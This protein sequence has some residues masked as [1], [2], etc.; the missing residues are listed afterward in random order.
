[1]TT[2]QLTDEQREQLL[3]SVAAVS[4]ALQEL[5]EACLPAVQAAAQQFAQITQALQ[6]AGYLDEDGKPA[7]PADR[8]AWQSPYGPA[9][10]RR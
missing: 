2:P 9:P 5:V 8:P 6:A 3:R 7:K 1:M 10:R 4:A